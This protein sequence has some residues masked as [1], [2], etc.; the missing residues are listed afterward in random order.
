LSNEPLPVLMT[1]HHRQNDALLIEEAME[2]WPKQPSLTAKV[3]PLHWSLSGSFL[4]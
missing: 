4:A 1:K 3:L 2:S